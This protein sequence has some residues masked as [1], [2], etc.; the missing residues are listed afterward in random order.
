MRFLALFKKSY[1]YLH[2]ILLTIYCS[3]KKEK[4]YQIVFIY[5]IPFLIATFML[6]IL[7]SPPLRTYVTMTIFLVP[8]S[9]IIYNDLLKRFKVY[10]LI[11]IYG[12]FI[13]TSIINIIVY[14]DVH[15]ILQGYFTI[16][17]EQKA[18]GI[19]NIKI[20]SQIIKTPIFDIQDFHNAS[21]GSVVKK[22][23]I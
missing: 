20:P 18:K 17:Q 2:M 10:S 11:F 7:K 1:M 3:Y 14:Q 21:W 6:S 15:K 22:I 5:L 9:I 12:L 8:I 16:I 19:T 4:N 23:K 13:C